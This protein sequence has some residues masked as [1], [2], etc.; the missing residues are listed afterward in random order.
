VGAVRDDLP[1]SLLLELLL[2]LS[3]GIDRWC[4]ENLHRYEHDRL[5]R[6]ADQFVWLF[7]RLAEPQA[8]D[9]KHRWLWEKAR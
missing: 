2:S 9:E 6:L 8:R 1:E 3:D 5:H 4:S 7:R